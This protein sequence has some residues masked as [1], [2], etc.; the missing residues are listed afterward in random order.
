MDM[1]GWTKPVPIDERSNE[2]KEGKE[3]EEEEYDIRRDIP[4]GMVVE[5]GIKRRFWGGGILCEK[6]RV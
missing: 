6:F 2:T 1:D 5:A 4:R 3:E